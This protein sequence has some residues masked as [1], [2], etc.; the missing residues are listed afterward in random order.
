[1]IKK[2]KTPLTDKDI[3]SLRAG[4]IVLITGTI[5]TAR[6]AAH[7][8]LVELIKEGKDLPLMPRMQLFTIL[9]QHLKSQVELLDLADQHQVTVW[10]LIHLLL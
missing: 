7:Q 3:E 10:I 8:R 9:V 4:D 1:M 2:L 5:Y 6:D